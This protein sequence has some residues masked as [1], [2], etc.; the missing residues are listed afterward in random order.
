MAGFGEA[1]ELGEEDLEFV[2]V[3]LP[4][5]EF[6]CHMHYGSLLD[7]GVTLSVARQEPLIWEALEQ[8]SSLAP[9]RS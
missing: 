7:V 6:V 4:V 2:V 1:L 3:C 8:I 9:T 5:A